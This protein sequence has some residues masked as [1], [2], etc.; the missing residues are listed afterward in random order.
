[1]DIN[2]LLGNKI[3]ALLVLS[4]DNRSYISGFSSSFG[5]AI[6][7][8]QHKYFVTDSRYE[9][10]AREKLA[11]WKVIIVK[12]G[13][14]YDALRTIVDETGVQNLGFEDGYLTHAQYLELKNELG[15][16]VS[17]KPASALLSAMR[18]VKT[19]EELEIMAVAQ[20]IAE[21][22]LSAAMDT[23]K[24]KITERDLTAELIYQM[25]K[26][27]AEDLAFHPIVAFGENS[28][29]PHHSF[30]ERKLTSEDLILID[31]GIKYKGYCSDMSRTFCLGDPG[32]E[33]NKV[34]QIVLKAQEYALA[35]I[36]AGITGHEADSFA[37]E[38]I[39]SKGYGDKFGH[40]TGHGVGLLIHEEPSLSI[41]SNDILLENM[42]VTVEPGIYIEGKG[43]VRIEDIIVV[44]N[45]G[46]HNLTHFDKKLKF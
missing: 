31:M 39:R 16:V 3:D 25:Y 14:L 33:L 44:K 22:A 42:V 19:P 28:A 30:G 46:I 40:G 38:Y 1:M 5:A 8:V 36:K 37:R 24:P 15:K 34:Y 13:G 18:A 4:G 26:H 23:V 32:E 6:V 29:K 43:G 12:K 10:A 41:G 20:K 7:G 35:N 17:L 45:D 11:D 21:E 27:G 2:S 9:L